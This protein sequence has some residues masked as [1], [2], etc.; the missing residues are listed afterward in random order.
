MEFL[1]ADGY[2]QSGV[3]EK[4]VLAYGICFNDVSCEQLPHYAT[5]KTFFYPPLLN[6][7]ELNVIEE[8]LVAAQLP[9]LQIREITWFAGVKILS[10]K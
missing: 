4:E 7:P 8:H 5:N 9:F 3:D 6:L 2:D 1:R 10:G